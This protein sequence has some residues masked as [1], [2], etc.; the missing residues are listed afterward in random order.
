MRAT[1][2]VVE[3]GLDI[4]H[5]AYQ[6]FYIV[7]APST[8][9]DQRIEQRPMA[10]YLS[11]LSPAKTRASFYAATRYAQKPRPAYRPSIS[12]HVAM[13]DGEALNLTKRFHPNTASRHKQTMA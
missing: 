8:L 1:D 10:Y 11:D 12:H 13:P 6:S 7:V 9:A 3:L 5:G 4:K 2:Q